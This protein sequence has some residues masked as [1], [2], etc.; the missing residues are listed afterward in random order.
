VLVV[1]DDD[2]EKEIDQ[3]IMRGIKAM[4]R[5]GFIRIEAQKMSI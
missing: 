5:R 4:F 3:S 1:K 2:D